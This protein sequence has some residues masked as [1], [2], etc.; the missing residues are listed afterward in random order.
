MGQHRPLGAARCPRGV[1]KRCKI[2]LAAR[3]GRKFRG[4]LHRRTGQTALP[5][6]IQGQDCR[7]AGFGNWGQGGQFRRITDHQRRIRISDEIG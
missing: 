6:G 4:V 5:R 1:K 7:L 2:I 3:H